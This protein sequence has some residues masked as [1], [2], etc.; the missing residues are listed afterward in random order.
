MEAS[1]GLIG[2]DMA[3][4]KGKDALARIENR[5]QDVD[6]DTPSF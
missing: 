2:V 1:A 6:P 5:P 4:G 3:S